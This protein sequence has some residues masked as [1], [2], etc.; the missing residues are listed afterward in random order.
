MKTPD[1]QSP[2]PSASLVQ[3]EEIPENIKGD[4]DAPEPTAEGDIQLEYSSD[5]LCSPNTGAVTKNYL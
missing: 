3:T 5:Y 2:G 1:A 4:P